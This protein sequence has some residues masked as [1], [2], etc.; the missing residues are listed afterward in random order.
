MSDSVMFKVETLGKH[1]RTKT[2]ITFLD[3]NRLLFDWDDENEE[4]TLVQ[5]MVEPEMAPF[6]DSPVEMLG[7]EL[8]RDKPM[9][10]VS[11]ESER[12]DNEEATAA[13]ENYQIEEN[14]LQATKQ[15]E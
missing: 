5:E 6:L 1:N 13:K 2:G 10:M 7:V 4:E 12:D 8:E 11:E 14:N 9:A 3:R 15:V